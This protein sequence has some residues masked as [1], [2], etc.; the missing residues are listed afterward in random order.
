MPDRKYQRSKIK[1]QIYISKIKKEEK[2]RKELTTKNTK[3]ERKR[4]R[5]DPR[6]RGDDNRN[7]FK[8]T[9]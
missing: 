6:F 3:V 5:L 1:Y 7:Y 2:K 4:K 8:A 9:A